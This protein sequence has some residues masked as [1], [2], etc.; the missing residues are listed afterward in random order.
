MGAGTCMP[1]F[2]LFMRDLNDSFAPDTPVKKVYGK[3]SFR[4]NLELD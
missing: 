3:K 4:D 1:L 2:T